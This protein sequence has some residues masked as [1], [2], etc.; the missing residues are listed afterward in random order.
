MVWMSKFRSL[1]LHYVSL[2]APTRLTL[3][4]AASSEV[5]CDLGDKPYIYVKLDLHVIDYDS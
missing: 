4:C 2:E 3:W 1:P 5:T